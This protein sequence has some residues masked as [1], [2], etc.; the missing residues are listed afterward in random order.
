VG[1]EAT[2]VLITVEPLL[3]DPLRKKQ[4]ILKTP[5]FPFLIEIILECPK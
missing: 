3:K 1:G 4:Y 2:T 5:K